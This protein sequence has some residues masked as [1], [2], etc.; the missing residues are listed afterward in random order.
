MTPKERVDTRPRRQEARPRAVHF[1]APFRR[2]Q[3]S[4][5][6]KHATSTLEFQ[7]KIPP[8]HRQGDERLPLPQRHRRKQWYELKPVDIPFPAQLVALELS[9]TASPATST[10]SRRFQPLECRRETLLQEA[11]YKLMRDKPQALLDA[12]EAIAKSEANHAVP[13]S[14][15]ALPASSS[16][17][18]TP[19]G[20]PDPTNTGNSASPLT[21]WSW[22]P[23][24]RAAEHPPPPRRQGLPR[25]LL[26]GLAR[27][28]HQLRRLRHQ[29]S[30]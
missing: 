17:S 27:P 28:G 10:S 7:R 21:A 8:R 18:P 12:L 23:R 4:P 6:F 29:A 11:S 2:R 26:E 13:P 3:N 20:P 19:R 1:L 24:G 30:A 9:A 15:P 16:P 5:A 14:P 25:S 22:P